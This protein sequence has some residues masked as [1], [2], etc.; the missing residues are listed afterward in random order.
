[1]GHSLTVWHGMINQKIFKLA[2]SNGS[3]WLS[4]IEV[5]KRTG[6]QLVIHPWNFIHQM[7]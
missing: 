4:A 6:K 3:Y 7:M 2:D 1:M 5:L